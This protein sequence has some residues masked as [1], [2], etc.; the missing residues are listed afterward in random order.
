[1]HEFN[2]KAPLVDQISGGVPKVEATLMGCVWKW[3]VPITWS[4]K[5]GKQDDRSW[6]FGESSEC[7][8][9]SFFQENPN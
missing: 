9:K 7:S 8:P 3:D 1:M 6:D 5:W 2:L 4:L